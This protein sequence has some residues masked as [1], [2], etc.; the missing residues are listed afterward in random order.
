METT[1]EEFY[2]AE[3]SE[4]DN[5]LN[6]E[7]KLNPDFYIH[8]ALIQAQKAILNPDLKTG[9]LQYRLIIEYIENI[10]KASNILSNEY[11]DKIKEFQDSPEYKGAEEAIKKDAMLANKK[12]NLI[13]SD[14]FSSRISSV[15]GKL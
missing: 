1:K 11:K 13:L 6:M 15:P 2:T 14:A 3:I 8:Y 12:L 10:A 4:D 5:L 7:V 9:I